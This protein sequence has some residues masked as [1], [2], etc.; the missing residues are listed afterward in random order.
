MYCN[1]LGG[2]LMAVI[3]IN[4]A[5]ELIY[6]LSVHIWKQAPTH[7]REAHGRDRASTAELWL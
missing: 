4:E 7:E 5:T 1:L 6:T 2:Y 3:N